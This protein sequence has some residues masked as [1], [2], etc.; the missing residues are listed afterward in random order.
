MIGD[1]LRDRIHRVISS[2]A[3]A[4]PEDGLAA[5]RVAKGLARRLN[6]T[7][8]KPICSSEEMAKRRGAAQRLDDLRA[9]RV[10]IAS[11]AKAAVAPVLVYFEKGRNERELARIREALDAKSIAYTMLDVAGDETTIA[12]VVNKAHCKSDDLPIVFVADRAVGNYAALVEADV[13][14][15][16]QRL[17]RGE[18]PT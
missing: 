13:S 7:L 12:F 14:G 8:G 1:I 10:A 18:L 16:L 2:P 11:A 5:V 17:L 4:V 6:E 3:G 15:A 9:G